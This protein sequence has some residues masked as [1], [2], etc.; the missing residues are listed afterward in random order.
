[1][2]VWVASVSVRFRSKERGKRVK[3]RAKNGAGKRAAKTGLPFPQNQMETLAS[4]ATTLF[5]Y[6]HANT[7]LGQSER[8]YY[9]SYFTKIEY[10]SE[11]MAQQV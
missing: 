10:S 2:L 9:L 1:M 5:T 11:K 3:H 8:A 7:P 4:Q 6:S